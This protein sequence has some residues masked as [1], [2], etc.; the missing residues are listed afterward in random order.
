MRTWS[1]EQSGSRII[2]LSRLLAVNQWP[3]C[4]NCICM[5]LQ[6]DLETCLCNNKKSLWGTLNCRLHISRRRG[7]RL[8][9]V[10]FLSVLTACIWKTT[11]LY[12]V[13]QI[14]WRLIISCH[15]Y[16]GFDHRL[17]YH[18]W[19]SLYCLFDRPYV[20]PSNCLRCER[21]A[22]DLFSRTV[23]IQSSYFDQIFCSHMTRGSR[24]AD[25]DRFSVA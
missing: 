1:S 14:E 21:K 12:F 22:Q 3:S 25:S 18:E 24:K 4:G 16:R 20:V 10:E 15:Q 5:P 6:N 19:Q 8:F 13:V 17:P 7:R 9:L 23:Y 2:V 11:P